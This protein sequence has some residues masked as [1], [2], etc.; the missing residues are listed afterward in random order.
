MAMH[1]YPDDRKCTPI[2][3]SLHQFINKGITYFNAI[4]DGS[5]IERMS[6]LKFILTGQKGLDLDTQRNITLNVSGAR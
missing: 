5:H 6:F 4:Q 3:M 1:T 2:Q